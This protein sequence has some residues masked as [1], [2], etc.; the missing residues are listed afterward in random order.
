MRQGPGSP[1]RPALAPVPPCPREP[2]ALG[3]K[4]MAT[5][6]L[7]LAVLGKPH[8]P[9]ALLGGGWGRGLGGHA[10]VPPLGTCAPG[11]SVRPAPGVLSP[12]W[13]ETLGR[14]VALRL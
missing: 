13:G 7:L 9:R 2:T 4:A 8:L 10:P 5:T 1:P 6:S 12:G 11:P 3:V 14:A